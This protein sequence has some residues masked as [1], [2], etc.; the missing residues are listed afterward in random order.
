MMTSTTRSIRSSDVLREQIAN[1]LN[2]AQVQKNSL[3]RHNSR[4]S[5]ANLVLSLFATILAT[6]A[7]NGTAGQWKQ[8]C[9]FAAMCS[10]GATVTAKMQ[11]TDQLAEV[12]ECVGE[13][14]ELVIA[15]IAPTYDMEIS[16][17][18]YRQIL[19]EFSTIDC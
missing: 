6:V 2:K 14:K 1:S 19:S 15:T 3:Q 4:C 17:E 9:L 5:T 18:K 10:A 8:L 7:L 13:L 12:S 11:P 16:Q